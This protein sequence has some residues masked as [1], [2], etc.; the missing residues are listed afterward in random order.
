MPIYM[1]STPVWKNRCF[2]NAAAAP[3]ENLRDG[4]GSASLG[5]ICSKTVTWIIYSNFSGIRA[6]THS[7]SHLNQPFPLADSGWRIVWT[8]LLDWLD[9]I[10]FHPVTNSSIIYG[11]EANWDVMMRCENRMKNCRERERERDCQCKTGGAGGGGG[12]RREVSRGEGW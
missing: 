10:Y 8:A 12:L 6:L 1:F 2:F 5:G 9:V 3:A 4:A 11:I 7:S